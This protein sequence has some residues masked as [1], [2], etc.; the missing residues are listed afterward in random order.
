MSRPNKLYG[1]YKGRL[2]VTAIQG[3]SPKI[4]ILC[5]QRFIVMPVPWVISSGIAL[6]SRYMFYCCFRWHKNVAKVNLWVFWSISDCV[7][8]CERCWIDCRVIYCTLAQQSYA[9][10]VVYAGCLYHSVWTDTRWI[11]VKTTER[12]IGQSA[13]IGSLIWTL[14]WS[15]DYKY[16][17][18]IIIIIK[19]F[20]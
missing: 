17:I 12:I 10:A 7:N 14:S 2:D 11:C 19:I 15:G 5:C 18:I 13:L 3:N 8:K 20:V 1:K 16:M 4:S 6:L 9:D